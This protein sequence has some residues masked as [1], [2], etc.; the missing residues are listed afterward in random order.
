MV[1]RSTSGPGAPPVGGVTGPAGA[2]GAAADLE[3]ELDALL[4]RVATWTATRWGAAGRA[5]AARSLVLALAEHGRRAGSGAPADAV[6]DGVAPHGLADQIAVLAAD[7]VAALR[8]RPSAAVAAAARADVD[9]ASRQ[10]G[11]G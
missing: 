8:L 5:D 11:G 2:G 1:P 3:C 6:P 7:L 10:V 4:R 9:R